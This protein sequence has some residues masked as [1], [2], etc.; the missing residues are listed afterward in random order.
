MKRYVLIIII[1]ITSF[2]LIGS[3]II[4]I[5][6]VKKGYNLKEE[7]FDSSV[8]IALKTVVNEIVNYENNEIPERYKRES[9]PCEENN[10]VVHKIKPVLLDSLIQ[11]QM[12][13]LDIHSDYVYGIYNADSKTF[14]L[15]KYQ[16]FT[17]KVK[18]SRYQASF[19]C[20]KDRKRYNLA[21][22][23]TD[24]QSLI[25]DELLGWAILSLIFVLVLIIGFYFSANSMLKQKKL[26]EMKNDF[27]NN[28]THEFKTPISTINL[29]GEMLLKDKVL[30]DG[31]KA[32]RYTRI[33]LDEN[34]RLKKQVEQVLQIAIIDRGEFKLKYQEVNMHD[35]LRGQANTFEVIVSERRG[36]I[37]Q[38]LEAENP[39]I[40]GDRTHLE[41][42]VANLID[43]AI[44]YVT[45]IPHIRI[46][47]TN[48]N[49]GIVV[50]VHDNGIGISSENKKQIFKNLYR[51][52]T[53]NVHN[54]KG[55]GLGLYYVKK[56]VEAHGG[57]ITLES[58]LGKGSSFYIYLPI[59]HQDYEKQ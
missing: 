12:K 35:I 33:I 29:T 31:D 36:T 41:N 10:S 16:G 57:N 42:V 11:S 55:F 59:K 37:Q 1:I 53:G 49:S 26:S 27:V 8:N 40:T 56:M 21:I 47:T 6:W 48:K 15:G 3:V 52:P 18:N 50:S 23:F 34:S 2:A 44:K 19:S 51:V 13:G 54:V 22:Y 4:Q 45:E 9:I 20:V 5:Y 30:K 17:Q 43:N 25:L 46:E 14:I 24:R 58:E 7:L 32:K 39:V 28:M 38:Q